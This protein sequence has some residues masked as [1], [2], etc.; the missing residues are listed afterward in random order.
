MISTIKEDTTSELVALLEL[1]ITKIP[2]WVAAF[3][4]VVLSFLLARLAQRRIENKMAEKGI[5]QEHQELQILG[6]RITYTVVLIIGITI[7]LKVAGIDLTSIIAAAAFGIGFALKDLIMNFLA[8]VMI[9]LGRH[10]TIG[11]FVKIGDTIG[12]VIEIQSRVTILQAI[13][14]TKVIVPNSQLFQKQVKSF[15]SNP[16]RRIELEFSIDSR[17]NLQ[18]AL[19]VCLKTTQTTEGII[20]EPKPAILVD[21]FSENGVKIIVRAWVESRGAWLKVKSRLA[22]NIKHALDAHGI[23]VPYPIQVAM[24]D[25]DPTASEKM[26][27]KAVVESQPAPSAN[28]PMEPLK[29]LSESTE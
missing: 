20:P 1:I 23:S 15:T 4:V 6:G 7:G 24:Q 9:L 17:N 11:D 21:G 8:G 27:E 26:L 3:I 2:L 18:N 19:D 10:F 16:F 25:K 13:D 22:K 5:D 14:G 12:K 29:P 28:P